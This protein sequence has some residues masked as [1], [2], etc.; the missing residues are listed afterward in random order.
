MF[1]TAVYQ[2]CMFC[3]KPLGSNEV[4]EEFPVGRRL[5]FDAAKGRLW[6]VCRSCE[7]WNLTPLEERWEAVE[8]CE[9]LFRGTRVRT[10]SEN[11]GLAKHREGLELVRIGKPLR[12]EFAAWRYGDQ[13]GRRRRRHIMIGTAVGVTW[14]GGIALTSSIALGGFLA[15]FVGMLPYGIILA[16]N[17][18]KQV[19]RFSH[20][21]GEVRTLTHAVCNA[22]RVAPADDEIGFRVETHLGKHLTPGV[23]RFWADKREWFEGED[24]RRAMNAVL[25][26]I[27]F[28]GA[29]TEAVKRAVAQ[30]ESHKHSS[31]FLSDVVGQSAHQNSQGV[32]GWIHQMPKPT[33]LALEMAVHEE[34]ER[35]A[36]EGELWRLEQ[37]W[38]E[39][40][41]IAAIADNLLLPKGTSRFMARH[42]DGPG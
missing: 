1:A 27:N 40:E 2:T 10:S 3:N 21:D 30:I 7:R 24:A 34:D 42:R 9:R 28:G 5:A 14:I 33:R 20:S 25:R 26:L 38:K 15:G 8:T 41:E 29:G 11:I 39:A 19:A 18:S 22:T 16:W 4:V 12:P 6:V 32:P 37:A 35:R 13:F 23:G 36:L 31:A 17:N